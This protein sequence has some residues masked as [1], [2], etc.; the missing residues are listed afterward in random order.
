MKNI[1]RL[2]CVAFDPFDGETL[3]AGTLGGGVVTAKWKRDK[4]RE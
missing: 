1:R 2:T 3:V 4:A